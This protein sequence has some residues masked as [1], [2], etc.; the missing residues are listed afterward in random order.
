MECFIKLVIYITIF[1]TA[2]AGWEWGGAAAAFTAALWHRK[3]GLAVCSRRRFVAR[4]QS[5]GRA[6]GD[7]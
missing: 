6:A 2:E 3:H 5:W 7:L 1:F 4:R